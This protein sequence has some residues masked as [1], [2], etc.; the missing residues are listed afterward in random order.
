MK[1]ANIYTMQNNR[2]E[3]GKREQKNKA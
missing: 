1:E 2:N 3:K